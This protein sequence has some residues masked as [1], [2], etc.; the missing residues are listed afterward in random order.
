MV[1]IKIILKENAGTFM[2]S[3]YLEI[4]FIRKTALKTK[5][6]NYVNLDFCFVIHMWLYVF[7]W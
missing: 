2:Q 7:L 3:N 1:L 5:V 4:I 6:Q